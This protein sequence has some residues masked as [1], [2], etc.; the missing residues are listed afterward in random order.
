MALCL[1]LTCPS[2]VRAAAQGKSGLQ[3]SSFSFSLLDVRGQKHTPAEFSASKAAVFFFIAVECPISNRYAPE[4][5]AIA[6]HY[7]DRNLS[8]FGVHSEPDLHVEAAKRHAEDY[9]YQFPVL[10]DAKQVLAS[11]F[12]VTMTPTVVVASSQGEVLYRGRIDNRYIDF[13]TFRNAGIIPDLRNALESIIGGRQV[14]VPR[15]RTIGCAIPDPR[16]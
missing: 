13:G 12:G 4:V 6:T 2:G 8:F 10:L 7:S 9:A 3:Q 14:A 16:G 1:A 15:T 5:N 11:K